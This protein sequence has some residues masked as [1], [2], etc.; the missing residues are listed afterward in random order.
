MGER[1][2]II[3]DDPTLGDILREKFS[4]AGYAVDIVTDG[5]IGLENMRK[6]KP[7]LVI[8]DIMLPTLNGYEVLEARKKDPDISS[9][10]VIIV[11]NSGQPVEISRAIALNAQDYFVKAQFN[12]DEILEKARAQLSKRAS[13][14]AA[15]LLGKKI[16]MVEDDKFLADVL[17]KQFSSE[18]CTVSH[19]MT[20]DE[21]LAAGAERYDAIILDL[22]LPGM[23]GF[24]ILA[25]LR[26]APANKNT[27]IM[28]LSNMARPED[29]ERAKKLGATM[30]L[31]KAMTTPSEIYAE[32]KKAI[33][34]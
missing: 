2:L 34:N 17:A 10:P 1:I 16:L 27:P 11:S 32:I 15:S 23:N 33:S 26:A 9:I 14:N 8:L 22:M 31:M 18:Q 7:D 30:F 4:S 12:P 3:E 13:K 5:A 25:A 24:E 19:A 29:V 21:A 20:G 6:K 28:V